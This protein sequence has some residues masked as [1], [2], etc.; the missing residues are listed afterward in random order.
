MQSCARASRRRAFC[1]LKLPNNKNRANN[2]RGAH[3]NDDRQESA[4]GGAR[5]GGPITGGSRPGGGCR[6]AVDLR[7]RERGGET[8]K[9]L[10]RIAMVLN[11][12]PRD[13]DPD[14]LRIADAPNKCS[15]RA[16]LRRNKLIAALPTEDARPHLD[17]LE[18]QQRLDTDYAFFA[19]E[20][21]GI[22]TKQGAI[23]PFVFNRVQQHVHKLLEAQLAG[24]GRV[25]ALIL[26]GR[27]QGCST[28]IGGRYYH[29]ASRNKGLRVFILTH[30][31]Q[32]T[33]NLFDMVERFHVNCPGPERPSTGAANAKELYFDRL[34]SGYRVGTAGTRGV[35]RS[36]TIQL[37]HGSGTQEHGR[38]RPRGHLAPGAD[39]DAGAP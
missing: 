9:F 11:K 26:K 39:R 33:Q 27:Q 12:A 25:R 32:A 18:R 21:L 28:Y 31:Q 29:R 23:E 13:L 30:A 35:G 7:P 37:F 8:S 16:W 38:V 14:W 36:A 15:A 6:P 34:D 2:K 20:V 19:K 10:P 24:T 4:Q 3:G 17:E 5:S 22:R 1:F